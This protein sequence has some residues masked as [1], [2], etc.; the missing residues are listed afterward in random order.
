[1][2][3]NATPT[4][5][6][7]TKPQI[8]SSQL[9]NVIMYDLDEIDGLL[10]M[11]NRDLSGLAMA[12]FTK[13]MDENVYGNVSIEGRALQRGLFFT[14]ESYNVQF[15]GFPVRGVVTEYGKA[16]TALVE[17]FVDTD[18]NMMDPQEITIQTLPK[19]N[20][21]AG[22]EEHDRIALEAAR[23]G[24]LLLKNEENVLPF[25][26]NETLNV[27]GKGLLQFRA[28]ALGAGKINPRYYVLFMRAV[29]EFSGFSLNSELKDLYMQDID[30][31][32]TEEMLDRAYE[33]SDTAIIMITRASGE[34]LDNRPIP[35]EYY[36]SAEEQAIIQAVTRKFDKTIAIV[37]S[38]YPIDVSWVEKYHI[39]GLIVCGFAGMLGGQALVEIL[40][41][42]V[43]PS[44]KLPDTWSLDYYDIPASK[45]F[46]NAT[47]GAAVLGTEAP[48]F[49]DTVYEEDI[50]VGYRYFE[51]FQKEVA[52][53]FGYGLSYTTFSVRPTHFEFDNHRLRLSVE[54]VNTGSI[55]GKEVVQIYV[56]EP[57]GL[58]EKPSRK[59][60]GFSKT[61]VLEAG[62]TQDLYFE[63]TEDQLTSFHTASAAWLMEKGTYTFY[64]GSSIKQLNEAGSFVLDETR[65]IRAVKNRMSP[66]VPIRALSKLD[67]EGTYPTGKHSGIKPNVTELTPK[68][69]RPRMTEAQPIKADA[70]S[71]LIKYPDV[72]ANPELLDSFIKQL[73][74]EELARLSVCKAAGWGMTDIGEAGRVFTLDQYEME[75]FIVADGNSGVNVNKPN[76]GMPAS[77]TVCATFN[78]QLAYEVGRVIAE[79]AIENGVHMIL[80]PGMNIHRNPLNGRH[81]EYFSEDPYLAGI[82]AG[83]QSK[84]LEENGISSCLKHTV[85]NNCET[86]RKRNNSLMT[87]RA[88]REIYLKAFEVAIQVHK[89][90]S[91]MTGYNACNGVFTA[92]DEEMIQGVFHEEFGFEGFVMTD[93]GSYDTVDVVEAVAA[94]NCWITPGSP[95]YTYVTPIVEGVNDGRIE[96]ARLEKNVKYLLNVT[97]KRS[98]KKQ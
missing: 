7:N 9:G 53:P 60:V 35:G 71:S 58:L 44:A 1:M 8:V 30:V 78:T 23:E 12:S 36:L 18:G 10:S 70:P 34:N 13:R 20:P 54:V 52:Y 96:R 47:E 67:P 94:G 95:D 27:F 87:E 91:I 68:A 89:P 84:G 31:C 11:L 97:I 88:L 69:N 5:D 66:P 93:W 98:S 64:A 6:Q 59:L 63:I 24:I 62:G 22:Y 55:A 75:D 42:R 56:D 43:N 65:T 49:A 16:Y 33:Q 48:Y 3:N 19:R 29:E 90:D 83:H 61:N 51:T 4:S 46:Y 85:A 80:A 57:D 26:E 45:N 41:G 25:N 17:G 21:D 15:F 92:A 82:M 73:S 79:E 28:G 32:P 40:D 86:V 76:I 50:Y 77:A 37:N 74:L 14:Y 81:P 39:K 2:D 38:G 72:V